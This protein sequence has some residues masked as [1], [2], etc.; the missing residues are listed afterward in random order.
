MTG[1]QFELGFLLRR[2][3]SGKEIRAIERGDQLP[4]I[5]QPCHAI[6][7]EFLKSSVAPDF[8]SDEGQAF[9]KVLRGNRGPKDQ[10]IEWWGWSAAGDREMA[11]AAANTG[12]LAYWKS[13][14]DD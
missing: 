9:M 4:K 13:D 3:T 11:R 10:A 14:P 5:G 12:A 6:I 1:L 2:Y 8:L 7:A